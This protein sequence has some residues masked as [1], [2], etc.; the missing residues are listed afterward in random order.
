MKNVYCVHDECVKFI[1]MLKCTEL[2]IVASSLDRPI[3]S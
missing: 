1:F 2:L 3:I